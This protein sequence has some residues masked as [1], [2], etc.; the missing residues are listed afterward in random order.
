[1]QF[2]EGRMPEKRYELWNMQTVRNKKEGAKA[3]QTRFVIISP[4]P[5]LA[6]IST[7][8]KFQLSSDMVTGLTYTTVRPSLVTD[9]YFPSLSRLVPFSTATYSHRQNRSQA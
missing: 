5:S 2:G 3:S 9:E 6:F 1:L 7:K 4:L 8:Y